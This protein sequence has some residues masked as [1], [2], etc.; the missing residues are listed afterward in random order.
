[1]NFIALFRF[2][3][4]RSIIAFILISII[5][6][7]TIS[8]QRKIDN[9]SI[10]GVQLKEVQILSS[11]SKDRFNEPVAISNVSSID[12]TTK[13][14][15]QEFPE[16]LKSTP[17]IYASKQGGGFGDSRITLRGF[18]SDNIALLINGVPVNGV[19]NGAVYWSNW[20]GLSDVA[21]T[22]QV[23][24]GIGL[25]KLGLYSVGGT[26]NIL[27]QG[28]SQ[29]P[30]GW[31]YYGLGNDNYQKM[32]ISLSTGE[33]K[34]GWA[35][36]F[37][38]TRTTGNGYVNAT[39]F[40]AWSYFFS[41]SKRFGYNHRLMFTAF[42]A[43][44]WHNRRSN[45]QSIEDYENNRD[46]IKM[47][48]SYGYINGEIT[49]TYSGYNEYHKPQLAL[50]HYWTID[51]SSSL[52]TVLYASFASGG[53]RKV[54]GADANRLQYNFRNGK[55]NANT[56]LTPDGLIDYAPVM[57]GNRNSATGSSA[58]FTM[59]TNSHNW[60]GLLSTYVKD[61]NNGLSVTAG[62]D[63]RYYVGYHY[64][65]ISDLL[66]GKY[67]IDKNLAWRD[68]AKE[69]HVGDKV[70][71]D[72]TSYI[73][74]LGAFGQLQ[75][76]KGR[77][78][79]FVSFSINDQMYQ[80]YDPGKYG[81]YSKQES[82]PESN[83]RTEWRHFVPISVKG[84]LNVK[85]GDIHKVYLNAGYVTK[86]PMFEN[87][88]NSNTPIANPKCE[89]ITSLELGYGL[90]TNEWDVLFSAY[91]TRWMDKSTTK[92]IGAWNGPKAC[93]PNLD[94]LHK[95]LEL[96]VS[97]R[98]IPQLKAS[99]YFSIGDWKWIDDVSFSYYDETGKH[100]GDY[101]AYIKDTH[102]GNVPQTSAALGLTY[103][104]FE[105]FNIGVDGNF[106]GRLYADFR[107]DERTNDKYRG[108]SWK[109]PAYCTVD[110]NANYALK[111]GHVTSQLYINVNNLLNNHYISEA[112]DGVDHNRETSYV[113]YGTGTTWTVGLRIKY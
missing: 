70:A 88:Y 75:Y 42:G 23:Q 72:Y 100:I 50:N 46:G 78:N 47:N 41:L 87:I 73:G 11:F 16:I 77:Y 32:G 43:P 76:T 5:S 109:L 84:G 31:L 33:T 30:E 105:N 6:I 15:N 65:E 10:D 92:P 66:G 91:Y 101:N 113:W 39:N 108:D 24:R 71:Q 96:E 64:D 58:V 69:L 52:S 94:A 102:V 1:M 45:K 38:G 63:G 48:T 110:L 25:S 49:P 14:S 107:P 22:I 62:V 85:L 13:L 8:A 35:A 80:R 21:R 111:I 55:P 97:Y 36:S 56:D 2:S 20:C 83:V 44:Q 18:S 95:G 54:V 28:T 27:T 26:I 37:I 104:L 9:D 40:E 51:A 67:Y 86:A 90:H 82:F 74:W 61:L 98:P 12:I 81:K 60:Y 57:T 93:I 79:S 17:S 34:N 4:L 103:N 59:G 99:G 53:G 106:Y 89:K 3:L 68:P 29:K 112:A 19:E 7:D